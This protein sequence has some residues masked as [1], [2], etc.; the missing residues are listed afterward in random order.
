MD[1]KPESLPPDLK[2]PSGGPGFSIAETVDDEVASS[3]LVDA[4]SGTILNDIV[5]TER[6]KAFDEA[7]SS[8]AVCPL[9]RSLAPWP[10]AGDMPADLPRK[11]FGGLDYPI[12]DPSTGLIVLQVTDDFASHFGGSTPMGGAQ[13]VLVTNGK[14][15]LGILLDEIGSLA[16][17][18]QEI[19]DQDREAFERYFSEVRPCKC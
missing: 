10:Y 16:K 13:G 9:D 3:I 8:I 4:E 14:S 17:G 15:Y 5:V 18:S 12:P 19:A 11:T 2:P 6:S 1:L 7:K